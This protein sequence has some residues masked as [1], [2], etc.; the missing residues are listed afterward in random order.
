VEQGQSNLGI[1]PL[2]TMDRVLAPGLVQRVMSV[3]IEASLTPVS[4]SPVAMNLTL[5][6]E[7]CAA[8]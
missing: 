2:L 7:R 4:K 3:P 1:G 6:A 8:S 5:G